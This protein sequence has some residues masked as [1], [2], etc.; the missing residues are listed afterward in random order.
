MS[1]ST[2]S[3][4]KSIPLGDIASQL[5]DWR[6]FSSSRVASTKSSAFKFDLELEPALAASRMVS[7]EVCWPV[8]ISKEKSELG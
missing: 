7:S 6:E 4:E 3:S 5:E 8:A 2:S 1:V